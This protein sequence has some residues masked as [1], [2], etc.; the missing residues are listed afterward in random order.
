MWTFSPMH[1]LQLHHMSYD[2][3]E[4]SRLVDLGVS[5]MKFYR[6]YPMGL[7]Y[8]SIPQGIIYIY[9]VKLGYEF[10]MEQFKYPVIATDWVLPQEMSSGHS[11]HTVDGRNPAPVDIR[12]ISH[13]LQGFSTIPGLIKTSQYTH[14]VMVRSTSLLWTGFSRQTLSSEFA[15]QFGPPPT[16]G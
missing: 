16:Y 9:I 12:Q 7:P 1:P 15:Q 5:A 2:F 10:L 13:Y 4:G 11:T 14:S 3:V 8:S 6:F